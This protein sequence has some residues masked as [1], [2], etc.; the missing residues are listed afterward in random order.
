MK[1]YAVEDAEEELGIAYA[2][3]DWHAVEL[4][5]DQLDR[6][7]PLRVVTVH[8]AALWYAEQG[9]PVFPTQPLSKQPHRGSRGLKDA[10]TD[11]N[12]INR[13]W[14]EH[15][16]SNVAIATGH[17]IDVVD[18]DGLPGHI[19]WGKTYRDRWA[20]LTRLASVSTPRP[21]GLHIWVPAQAKSRNGAKMMPGVDYRG[22]GGYV[23]APPSVL[24]SRDGQHAGT[25]AFL[26]KP[27][28]L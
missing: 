19:A 26:L 2:A 13:W 20:G 18:F 6:L 22:L 9:L 14:G 5:A 3:Q 24:D 21:G 4:I 1:P 17:R 7:S 23:L 27:T 8:A 11:A 28:T 25:Y 16:D 15:E 12:Q 10:T